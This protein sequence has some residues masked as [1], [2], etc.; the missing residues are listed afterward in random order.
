MDNKAYISMTVLILLIIISLFSFNILNQLDNELKITGMNREKNRMENNIYNR[1]L[2]IVENKDCFEGEILQTFKNKSNL[3]LSDKIKLDNRNFCISFYKTSDG[4]VNLLVDERDNKDNSFII[5]YG[6]IIKDIFKEDLINIEKLN[7]VDREYL[8]KFMVEISNYE[9]FYIK[10][11][12]LID[13]PRE[14][15]DSYR[16]KYIDGNLTIA[17]DIYLEGIVIINGELTIEDGASLELAGKLIC[18]KTEAIE[19]ISVDREKEN[20]LLYYCKYIPGFL[21]YKP[22]VIKVY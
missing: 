3:L 18:K 5:S 14:L 19:A 11:Y 7:E 1:F 9:S 2:E 13:D 6:E 22:E 4:Q 12:N 17:E 10:K 16:I 8:D 15:Q 20:I 21:E